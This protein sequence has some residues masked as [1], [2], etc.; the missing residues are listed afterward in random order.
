VAASV[1]VSALDFSW[2]DGTTVFR[3]LT[4]IL[5]AGVNSLVGANGTGKSTLLRLLAG[6]LRPRAGSVSRTGVTGYVPQ[7]PQADP[8]ATVADALDIGRAVAALRR[9]EAGS[10]DPHDFDALG[11]DWDIEE[12]AVAMLDG[13]GLRPGGL[14]RPVGTLSGGEATGL[15]IAGQL[16]R[17]PDT[18]LLDEPTNNLDQRAR[19]LLSSALERF[20]GTVV[21]VSHDLTLLEQVDTTVELY[22]G[23]LRVF[24]GPYS[25]YRR[26]LDAEQSAAEQAVVTATVD[27]KAQRRDLVQ[28]R[29]KLDRRA[30]FAARAEQEKRV[31]KIAAGLRKQAAEVSA[32]KH[33]ALHEDRADAARVALDAAK[34]KVRDDRAVRISMPSPGP[35]LHRV[36]LDHG[37]LTV[38]GP[39]RIAVVGPNG[40]GKTTLL[41]AALA[42]ARSGQPP[43]AAGYVPQDL[44]FPDESRS[45]IDVVR[46]AR[47]ALDAETAHAALARMLLRGRDAERIVGTLSGGERLRV[48]LAVALLPDP[49]PT[50]L[51]LD[52]PTNNL[53]LPSVELLVAA[54]RDWSG[55]LVVISHDSAFL[56]RLALRTVR[57]GD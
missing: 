9:I 47:P 54:L 53:D 38:A 39:E 10:T 57:I 44:R 40:A 35:G 33:R 22:R 11:E 18:L 20:T 8:Q 31:P 32:G 16:L 3:G 49:A 51:A 34:G 42:A 37:P 43:L 46:T 45:A 25:Q 7:R 13:L 24:G 17:R 21:V 50:L 19:R 15:A 4:G 29:T 41:R 27:L 14:D 30:R 5:P 48:A 55:A 56:D 23:E 52:E 28:A 6:D 2:P 26:L 36:Q 1:T 12:R